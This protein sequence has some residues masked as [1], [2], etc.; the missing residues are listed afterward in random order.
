MPRR[1]KVLI[2]DDSIRPQGLEL[3]RQSTELQQL[4][5]YSSE[6]EIIEAASEVD[7]ILLRTGTISAPVV[8]TAPRLKIVSRHGVGYD[9]IDVEA[10]T[11]HGVVVSITESANAQAVS[12]HAFACMLALANRIV[13][14]NAGIRQGRWD[15]AVNVGLELSGKVL[16]IFG[17]GRI[18]SRVARQATAFDMRVI[19]CDPYI[20]EARVAEFKAELVDA[21]ALLQQ[22]DFVTLHLPLSAETR[23]L[24]GARELRVMKP[25]AYLVNTSRS[26]IIDE[27][28]LYEALTS[29]EIAGAALDVFEQEPVAANH[30]LFEL[31]NLL[32]CSPH[33][34]GQ[35]E[36]SMVRMSVDAAQNILRVFRGEPPSFAVNPE[37]LNDHSRVAWRC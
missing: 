1:N 32:L 7:G 30:P 10:C 17:L 5:A 19:T 15:R 11:R 34:A 2:A 22:A 36:E 25:T 29:G 21:N 4:P 26:G 37:V 33:V 14:A 13:A 31:D 20:P 8:E 23:N 3:L 24:I 6:A 9:N 16:G 12:E 35:S 18:G 28:A 27:T